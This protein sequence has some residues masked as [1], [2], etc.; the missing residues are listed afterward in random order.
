MIWVKFVEIVKY[1]IGLLVG[2]LGVFVVMLVNW[3]VVL[4]WVVCDMVGC[5]CSVDKLVVI[6]I[7]GL[8][9]GGGCVIYLCD[10]VGLLVIFD[11]SIYV[12]WGGKC[13]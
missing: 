11:G 3:G 9:I 10:D 8:I 7:V 4:V 13:L 5:L 1:L 2:I 6:L 12:I